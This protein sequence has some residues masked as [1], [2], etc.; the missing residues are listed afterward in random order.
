MGWPPKCRSRGILI[1]L[2][3]PGATGLVMFI[4]W[5]IIISGRDRGYM[6]GRQWSMSVNALLVLL[7]LAACSS[8]RPSVASTAPVAR[9]TITNQVN[10]SGAVSAGASQ[11]LGFA[12]GGR[13][14]SLK[15]EVGDHVVAGQVLAKIDT[16]AARQVVRQQRANLAAQQAALDR[17]IANPAVSGARATLTQSRVILTATRRQVSAVSTADD[18]A[19]TRAR[20]QLRAARKAKQKANDALDAAQDACKVPD[21]PP[22]ATTPPP[23]SAA[24]T[25]PPTSAAPTPP[26]ASAAP[27]PRATPSTCGVQVAMASSAQASAEQG[28][29]AAKTTL[30]A[31]EQKKKVDAAAGQVSV[32]T[33]RQSVVTAQ[34]ALNS[35]SSDRP[36]AIDQQLALVDAAEAL[37]RSAQKDV[38]DGTLTA[39]ADGVIS[40]INGVVGEYLSPSSGTTALA[41]GSHAAIPGSASAGGAAEAAATGTTATRPG[42][43]QFVVLSS[44][45]GFQAVIPFEESDAAKIAPEQL[46][47][48]SFD[49]I[50]GLI[51]SGTV[52]SVAPS[53]TAIAGVISYYVTVDLEDADSRLRDGQTARAEVITAERTNV[54]SVPNAAVRRQGDTDTVVVVDS[55]GRQRVVTFQ[56][57][58]VGADRTEVLSGLSEGQRV[59]VS[60]GG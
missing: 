21:P 44:V 49:A 16:Y 37:V 31:A 7:V 4:G 33:S 9:A 60:P 1:I 40:A 14:T 3:M 42:G 54:V 22:A 12:K 18:S 11:N 47:S 28:V 55:D 24:P 35:A 13:L 41:P 17:I 34:N 36:H 26:P 53:A 43:S 30:A 20:A 6:R 15:V 23:T 10:S 19:I 25:P 48:V 29:E 58:L 51:E 50:P 52:V 56:P 5:W 38:D 46:V 32:E 2:G 27:T 39:P 45:K 57:G 8:G 59:V